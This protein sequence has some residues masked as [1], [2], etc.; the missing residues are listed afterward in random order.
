MYVPL[1]CVC[2]V[3]SHVNTWF[4]RY[5]QVYTLDMLKYTRQLCPDDLLCLGN[6]YSSAPK[7]VYGRGAD[8]VLLSTGSCTYLYVHACTG[9]YTAMHVCTVYIL[10]CTCIYH[11]RL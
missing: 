4:N 10:V 2:T 8:K 6:V 1:Q 11:A 7:M 9:I 5:I 3:I